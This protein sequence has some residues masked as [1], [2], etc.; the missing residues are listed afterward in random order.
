MSVGKALTQALAAGDPAAFAALYD[1]LGP[2]LYATAHTLTGSAAEAEDIVHDLFVELATHRHRLNE[3]N[4][5]EAY[6]F[7]SLRHIV[8]RRWRRRDVHRRALEQLATE[9]R[10]GSPDAHASPVPDEELARAI[11]HLPEAQ[12][13]VLALKIDGGLTFAEIARVTGTSLNTAASRYR[14]ALSQL[15]QLLTAAQPTS[16]PSRTITS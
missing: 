6:L 13:E 9:H 7:T 12:R 16:R 11:A 15:R 5:L 3:V 2:R 4:D 14:Y 10:D 8:S 1:R